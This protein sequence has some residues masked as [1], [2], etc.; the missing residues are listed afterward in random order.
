MANL[1]ART[2]RA[3]ASLR[4]SAH[5]NRIVV[6]KH[7]G[8]ASLRLKER[9]AHL[10]HGGVFTLHG[11]HRT[12]PGVGRYYNH[13]PTHTPFK[14][15]EPCGHGGSGG[16]YVRRILLGGGAA[17]RGATNDGTAAEIAAAQ[18][19][20]LTKRADL[21]ARYA[22]LHHGRYPHR[23]VQE[24]RRYI[25]AGEYTRQL[26]LRTA[27]LNHDDVALRVSAYDCAGV[28]LKCDAGEPRCCPPVKI[29]LGGP[30]PRRR[31]RADPDSPLVKLLADA[32]PQSEYIKTRYMRRVNLPTPANRQHFPTAGLAAGCGASS[33]LRTWQEA[34]A[35]KALPATY[36]PHT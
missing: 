27:C 10:S 29:A 34:V 2:A 5:N 23:W 9:H 7:G 19:A 26:T 28:C 21:R 13:T 16:R 35:A 15:T 20:T 14:G 4:A 1:S 8:A 24:T 6:P 32:V 36:R 30:A 25:D 12:T 18:P 22:A 17:Q 3:R 33:A 11:V 31:L